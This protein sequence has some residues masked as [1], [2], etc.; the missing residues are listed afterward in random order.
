ER[1]LFS[2]SEVKKA[3]TYTTSRPGLFVANVEL[4]DDVKR[5]AEFWAMLRHDLNESAVL[6]LPPGVIGPI[7]DADFGDVSEVLLSVRAPDG[8]YGPRELRTFLDRVE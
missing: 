8:R 3:K 2:R 7:V 4:E 1:R 5:P 6:D